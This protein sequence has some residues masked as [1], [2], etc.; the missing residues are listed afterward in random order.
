MSLPAGVIEKARAEY[1]FEWVNELSKTSGMPRYAYFN[2]RRLAGETTPIIVIW[3]GNYIV[4]S[5]FTEPGYTEVAVAAEDSV[6]FFSGII[7]IPE[8]ARAPESS[9]APREQR[10]LWQQLGYETQ[11]AGEAVEGAVVEL[12]AIT[13]ET[14][15]DYF[16]AVANETGELVTN[17]KLQKLVYYAQAWHMAI[18]SEPLFKAE[19]QAWVHGPAIPE[20]YHKYKP[21]GYRPIESDLRLEDVL[22]SFDE[23]RIEFLEEVT[24]VYMP[25]SAYELELMVHHEDPW[26]EARR[27][28]KSDE[29]CEVAISEGS[30][31]IYYASKIQDQ[32]DKAAGSAE[33]DPR[34]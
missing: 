26:I 14:V 4:R 27:G 15:A 18:Y 33:K 30:M 34:V 20:L 25:Y 11:A 28:C 3:P 10:D 9:T 29:A 32:G 7:N 5:S 23:E 31:K 21:W 2:A 12:P 22:E 24:E 16:L 19:F 8:E 17:L 1:G 6:Q 13:C